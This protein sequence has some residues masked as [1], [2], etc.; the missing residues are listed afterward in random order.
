MVTF[1]VAYVLL[2]FFSLWLMKFHLIGHIAEHF[3]DQKA[4]QVI[5]VIFT[6][7]FALLTAPLYFHLV[8]AKSPPMYQEEPPL[9]EFEG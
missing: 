9:F 7:L 3:K 6:V 2:G 5:L 8:I 1:F 4:L